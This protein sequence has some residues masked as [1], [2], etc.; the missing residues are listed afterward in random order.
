MSLSPGARLGK[1]EILSLIGAGGMGE[2]YRAR[3]PRLKR[4]IAVKVLPAVWASDA[5]RLARFQR[6]AELLATLNHP[7][8]AAIYGFEEADETQALLLELVEGPTLADR[9]RRGPIPITEASSIAR[10]IA[11]ALDAAHE[12]G[13]VHRDLKPAN[14]K[15][16]DDGMV[17]V[18]D[19]GLAKALEPE[20][21]AGAATQLP[22]VTDPG[23][24]RAGVILGTAAYMSPEQ[25]RGQAVDKRT[26]IWAFGCVLYE[27]LMGRAP[28]VRPTVTDTLAAVVEQHPNWT[29]LPPATPEFVVRLLRRCL[30]KDVRRRW[31]DIADARLYLEDLDNPPP[32][33]PHGLAR[34]RI[35]QVVAALGVLAVVAASA[36][37]WNSRRGEDAPASDPVRF[38]VDLQPGEELPLDAGLPVPMAISRDGRSIVYVTRR[39]SGNRIYLRQTERVD[40]N[41]IAGTDGGSGPFISPDGQWLGFASGGFIRK[42]SMQGG[43]PQTVAR[44]AT[45]FGGCWSDDGSIVFHEWQSGL[46]RVSADGGTPERLTSQDE[47]AEGPGHQTPFC[48]PG[49]R[50]VLFSVSPRG[51]PRA[52]EAVEIR[53]GRRTH[54]LEGSSPQYVSSGHLV[55]VRD[56]KLHAAPFD[57]ARLD[58][59]GPAVALADDIAVTVVQDRGALAISLNGTLAYAPAV[60]NSSRLVAVDAAGGSRPVVEGQSRFDHPRFSPDGTRL[61]V[62]V[63]LDTGNEL[64][65]YDLARNAR[66]RLSVGGQVSRPIWSHDGLSIT[67]QREGS[68]YSMPA[69]DSRTPGVLLARDQ[70]ANALFPLAWSRVGP[71]LVYSR[72]APGTNRDVFTLSADG[73]PTPFL[74]TPRD[75][76]SAMLSPDGRWMVYAALEA[77][78]EEE[79]YVER[80]PGPGER[81]V[82]SV[83]GGR[84]PVWSPFGDEIFY[85][86]TDGQRMMAVTVRAD[87]AVNIGRPRTLFQGAFRTGLFWANYDVHPKTR[88]FVM[89]AA[90]GPL[91]PRLTVALNWTRVL[92]Q[93]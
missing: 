69:D 13:I 74:V 81:V 68:L 92:G 61:V 12:R 83:G 80:N 57:V 88:E 25:A 62:S 4:D 70:S 27:M 72:P 37:V 1:V 34:R 20:P 7:N 44:V 28:F 33:E 78:R 85:R 75:E 8:V 18:L 30:E 10:Q 35:P 29:A 42:V 32:V 73:V 41:M 54:L 6:E 9:L 76:R 36:A 64:W 93:R 59:T 26:D 22:T 84:E 71:T 66:A 63:A 5:D 67:F 43:T 58:V 56:G 31:H 19:F 15:V 11:D 52:V 50:A 65:V 3:D 60:S 51:R 53:T 77:G 49:G 86:S 79:V 89:L 46:F 16:R 48:L 2:V 17:K 55:F 47:Q 38:T 24:T 21:S 91:Q 23:M 82:V 45:F 39:P 40:A 90:E 14:I 87:P